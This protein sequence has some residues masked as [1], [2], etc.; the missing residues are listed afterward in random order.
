MAMHIAG[1]DTIFLKVT[2]LE[3]ATDWYHRVLGI[4]PG[5]RFGDW[6]VLDVG[7]EVT[8][9]LHRFATPPAGINAV[10][11]LRVD[12]LD[13]AIDQAVARGA[14]P[15]DPDITDTGAKRFTTFADPDGNHVQLIASL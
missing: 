7:G 13:A 9:A 2:D 6:Q 1:V 11:S 3:R 5:P 15:I 8:F 12:D 4:A 14:Q 10:V